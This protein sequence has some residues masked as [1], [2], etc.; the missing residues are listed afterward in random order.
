MIST[1]GGASYTP[2]ANANTVDGPLGPALNGVATAFATQTFDLTAYAGKTVLLA[3]RYVSDGGVNE[4]GWFVDNV[5]VGDTLVSDGTDVDVFKSATQVYATPIYAFN[6]RLV[7][8]NR[9]KHT[10]LVQTHAKRSFTLT[11]SQ[12]KAL[13][14]Y[15]RVVAVVSYDEPTEQ[16]Q[17]QAQYTLTANK[18]VQPGGR[19]EMTATKTAARR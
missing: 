14:K 15:P 12:V 5:K 6:V 8:I 19:E 4:G 13:R 16:Y 18:V 2:L 7:G 10:V 1:D 3:F 11:K 9:A 17:P